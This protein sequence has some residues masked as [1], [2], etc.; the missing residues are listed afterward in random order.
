MR[1]FKFSFSIRKQV[2]IDLIIFFLIVL[3][4]KTK[5]LRL[6]R[7]IEKDFFFFYKD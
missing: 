6:L 5:D 4:D 3:G 2:S 1:I 7:D